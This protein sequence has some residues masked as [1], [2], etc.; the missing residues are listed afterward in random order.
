[1]V[2]LLI[3]GIGIFYSVNRKRIVIKSKTIAVK[4]LLGSFS[5]NRKFVMIN[6]SKNFYSV[7]SC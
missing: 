7:V 1:M 6:F 4:F 5:L 2:N 3:V